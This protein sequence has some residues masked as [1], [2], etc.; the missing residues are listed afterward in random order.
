MTKLDEM[1]GVERIEWCDTIE[2]IV[3]SI[4][5]ELEEEEEEEIVSNP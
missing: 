3:P 1:F 2:P 5:I 4:I